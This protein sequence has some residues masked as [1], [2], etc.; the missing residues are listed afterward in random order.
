MRTENTRYLF[1]VS[2][3]LFW[4]SL[5]FGIPLTFLLLPGCLVLPSVLETGY[6]SGIYEGTGQGYRGPVHVQV[7]VAQSG[8]EGIVITGHSDST[9]PGAA[10]MEELLEQVLEYG[11]LDLDVIAGATYSSRGFLDAVENAVSQAR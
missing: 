7:Q 6:V 10:A 1:L 11:S 4:V 2:R 5:F 3:A 9:F 8:I